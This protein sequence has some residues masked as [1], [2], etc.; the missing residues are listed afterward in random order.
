MKMSGEQKLT[1]FIQAV[2]DWTKSKYLAP[3]NPPE[4]IEL[5]LNASTDDIKSWNSETCNINAFKLYAYAEYIETENT[6]E[7]NT[8]SKL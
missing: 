7:K 6:K 1:K 8:T 3:V 4:D 5:V 2:E